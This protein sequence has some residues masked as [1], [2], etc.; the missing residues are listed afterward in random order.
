MIS[1]SAGSQPDPDTF[2]SRYVAEKMPDTIKD[3][4]DGEDGRWPFPGEE[5]LRGK[6]PM[7]VGRRVANGEIVL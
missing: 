6:E 4:Q 2:L 1:T 5:A 7:T 3:L